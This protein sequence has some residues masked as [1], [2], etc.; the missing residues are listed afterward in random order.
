LLGWIAVTGGA[1]WLCW[2]AFRSHYRT[3]DL[4]RPSLG[5][6]IHGMGAA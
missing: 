1:G 6:K 2:L 4:N 3:C 5:A